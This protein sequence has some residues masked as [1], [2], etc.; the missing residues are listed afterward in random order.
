MSTKQSNFEGKFF[1]LRESSLFDF[2]LVK[3]IVFINDNIQLI[4]AMNEKYGE[5]IVQ[6]N[7]TGEINESLENIRNRVFE[8]KKKVENL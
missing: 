6:I 1:V 7:F 4:N 3:Q 2:P 5:K 8:V